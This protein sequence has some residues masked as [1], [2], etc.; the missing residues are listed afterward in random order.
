MA[1]KINNSEV[2]DVLYNGSQVS[3]VQLNGV[4]VWE[5][6]KGGANLSGIPSLIASLTT[7]FDEPAYSVYDIKANGDHFAIANGISNIKI[8]PNWLPEEDNSSD[9]EVMF[10]KISSVGPASIGGTFDQWLSLTITNQIVSLYA[11]EKNAS[12]NLKIGITVRKKDLSVSA[13]K[14]TTLRVLWSD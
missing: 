11:N 2:E 12:S 9:Y 7:D 5:R 1:L 8:S 3:E 14:E 13:Y 10:T 6:D 4:T